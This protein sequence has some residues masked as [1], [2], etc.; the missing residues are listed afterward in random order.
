ME[1]LAARAEARLLDV[2]ARF[3]AG[4][5]EVV[6]EFFAREHSTEEYLDALL[7]F[8]ALTIVPLTV[9][10]QAH[11]EEFTDRGRIAVRSEWVVSPLPTEVPS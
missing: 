3:T 10:G 7:H 2:I 9:D 6:Q 4:E 1:P 5:A 8:G 11:V